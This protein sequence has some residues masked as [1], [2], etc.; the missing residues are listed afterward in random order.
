MS[1]N[2]ADIHSRVAAHLFLF[3]TLGMCVL[4]LIR[5]IHI[6]KCKY[7]YSNVVLLDSFKLCYRL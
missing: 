6:E 4:H 2:D 3:E 7:F 1:F 5:L